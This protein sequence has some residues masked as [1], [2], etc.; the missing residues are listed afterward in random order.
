MD[1]SGH[2]DTSTSFGKS[3]SEI[4]GLDF[5][6]IVF[7]AA[8]I[9]ITYIL[10]V[11]IYCSCQSRIKGEAPIETPAAPGQSE[12]VPATEQTGPSETPAQATTVQDLE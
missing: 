5:V 1:A 7:F 10:V 9:M 4:F 8:L 11:W 3:D 12:L 2:L 6:L